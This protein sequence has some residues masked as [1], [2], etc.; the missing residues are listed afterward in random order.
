MSRLVP[1]SW[2]LHV[3]F[4][5]SKPCLKQGYHSV[6][7]AVL[8]TV[9]KWCVSALQ[10]LMCGKVEVSPDVLLREVTRQALHK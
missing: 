5:K 3:P 2:L 7:W 9:L 6:Y 4:P 1:V 8:S 10:L